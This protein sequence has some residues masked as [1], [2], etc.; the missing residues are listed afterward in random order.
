MENYTVFLCRRAK[1]YGCSIGVFMGFN[2]QIAKYMLGAA[3]L[4]QLPDD[5]GVE[6]AF[7]GRSNAG[8][9]SAL[10]RLTNRK[11]L[12]RTS[13]TPGRTQ[14]INLFDIDDGN[15]LVDLP[16]YGYARVAKAV[17]EH[18]QK[19]LS[20]YLE[21]RSCL[22]GLV[23][24]MDIRHPCKDMDLSMINWAL[25]ADLQVLILLSKSDKIKQGA[26]MDTKRKVHKILMDSM[27]QPENLS[28]STFSALKGDGVD[29]LKAFLDGLYQKKTDPV[30]GT[31]D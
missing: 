1:M 15:R 12:A 8:K 14:L 28:I 6:V 27:L 17:K 24:L 20:L 16:G 10:N 29:N 19:T 2:Y 26:R 11:A 18:W 3:N 31:G 7:A 25:E 21:S 9:S 30:E 22:K 23:V 4:K 13:K 5:E